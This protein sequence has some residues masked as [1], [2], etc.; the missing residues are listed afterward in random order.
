VYRQEHGWPKDEDGTDA[1]CRWCCGLDLDAVG[2]AG[3]EEVV[4]LLCDRCGCAWCAS[5]LGSALGSNYV[6]KI[7]GDE[8][9]EWLCPLCKPALVKRVQ[10]RA[11]R[12]RPS[13]NAIDLCDGADMEVFHR[14]DQDE[15][16]GKV[17]RGRAFGG[18]GRG[19]GGPARG[20]GRGR[21]RPET[22]AGE[23]GACLA[24]GCGRPG[25]ANHPSM[26]LPLC[27]DHCRAQVYRQEHGWPKDE[28]GTDALC[29][30]CCGLDLDAVGDAGK[31]E[32]V[33]LLCDRCGCAWCAS[34]LGSALGSNYVEKI[35]GDEEGEWLCPLCKPAL[36]KRVQKRIDRAKSLLS[37]G[38]ADD[39]LKNPRRSQWRSRGEDERVRRL[40]KR[41]SQGGRPSRG[42]IHAACLGACVAAGCGRRG[43][44][45]HP[46]VPL[47]L[48]DEHCRAQAYWREHGWPQDED[49]TDARCRGCCGLDLNAADSTETNEVTT[50]LCDDC[51]MA[52]CAACLSAVLGAEYMNEIIAEEGEWRCLM[53]DRE[54]F[55]RARAKL[56]Q[57]RTAE[58]SSGSDAEVESD[59]CENSS[60]E[61]ASEE[62]SA[63]LTEDSVSEGDE[64]QEPR[65]RR[66]PG[67]PKLLKLTSKAQFVPFLQHPGIPPSSPPPPQLPALPHLMP[68]EDGLTL[69]PSVKD[70]GAIPKLRVVVQTD[71]QGGG[72]EQRI[73]TGS[74]LSV[75]AGGA[76]AILANAGAPVWCMAWMPR[77]DDGGAQILAVGTH[78]MNASHALSSGL[79]EISLWEVAT[80][81][82]E[83]T[84][85][86][87]RLQSFVLHDG[88]GALDLCW[89]P[90]G[91]AAI[92]CDGMADGTLPRLGLLAVA[93][94]DGA[95]RI[96]AIPDAL[97]LAARTARDQPPRIRLAPAIQLAPAS[98]SLAL[99][100]AW[101]PGAPFGILAVG[102]ADGSVQLWDLAA[103]TDPSE[104]TP[105]APTRLV[106]SPHTLLGQA[107]R[108]AAWQN[109]ELGATADMKLD[110]ATITG[111]FG[112]VRTM[113]WLPAQRP[114]L[115]T[116]GHD[117]MCFVW[118]PAVDVWAPRQ[119]HHASIGW[120]TDIE[121][122][123]ACVPAS[124][125]ASDAIS[126]LV[127]ACDSSR[128]LVEPT[129]WVP[130]ARRGFH[131]PCSDTGGVWSLALS[132]AGDR[133]AI[134]TSEGRLQIAVEVRRSS[135]AVITQRALVQLDIEDASSGASATDREET[136]TVRVR[137]GS[138]AAV[139]PTPAPNLN[140]ISLEQRRASLRRVQWCP[141]RA[142]PNLLACAGAAGMI[143]VTEAPSVS[144]LTGR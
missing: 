22:T 27:D 62:F 144:A 122:A 129:T 121:W 41:D 88:G 2:D 61:S 97:G 48:C 112:P 24:A 53:C 52:W 115:A 14:G 36:V 66:G 81:A 9:G 32:V 63:S 37:R 92:P 55:D 58:D 15:D 23:I 116:G 6:E 47:P 40:A 21:V 134:A 107:T 128:L 51:C 124:G 80:G 69:E 140:T 108:S 105:H 29:R 12:A 109:G 67:R 119:R 123:H 102:R 114:L 76:D 98:K 79:N 45:Y 100:L 133:L 84:A 126:F 82:G 49:G 19:R 73:A 95:V 120:V 142:R 85:S 93:C 65:P 103:D 34:C 39:G 131:V 74:S 87:L 10:K 94:A 71:Q 5:C 78:R 139:A 1:L 18:R 111:H 4:S 13:P 26:P 31:E 44:E 86:P 118:D 138:I 90:A 20:R 42:D 127:V 113:A 7:M 83:R 104:A 11:A 106:S 135:G 3:K 99:C 57:Q 136:S 91:N 96:F 25:V 89:C 70:E 30:W 125:K 46:L 43:V 117:G 38:E 35:M 141:S 54:L 110:V 132:A 72:S 68:R 60:V 33:S 64:E 59:A 130:G 75:S 143:V 8:E 16:F 17:S 28:D 50:L 101:R 137:L 56:Q 77:P